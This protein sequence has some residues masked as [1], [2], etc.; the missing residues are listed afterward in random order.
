MTAT[1]IVDLRVVPIDRLDPHSRNVRRDLGDLGELADSIREQGLLEPLVVAGDGEAKRFTVV[2][3]HRRLAAAKLAGLTELPVLVR[4]D[5]VRDVDV[6]L[7]M[8]VENLQRADLTPVEE[9][10]AYEQ[11][12]LAGLSPA[13]IAKRTGRSRSTVDARLRLMDL[14]EQVRDQVHGRQVT[15]HEAA[16]LLEFTDRPDDL[17]ALE[18]AA[19]TRDFE[20]ELNRARAR[21]EKQ[22]EMARVRSELEARKVRIVTQSEVP[23]YWT[24]QL[25]WLHLDEAEHERSCPDHAAFITPGGYVQYLCLKP[26]QHPGREAQAPTQDDPEY[27]ER[28]AAAEA[29]REA[30]AA[31]AQT[32]RGFLLPLTTST[33]PAP[34]GLRDTVLRYLAGLLA[35][36]EYLDA[37][38]GGAW[39]FLTGKDTA[40]RKALGDPADAVR[41]L[42]A[43]RDPLRVVLAHLASSAE[44]ALT[45]TWAW[46]DLRALAEHLPWLEL[47]EQLGYE[48]STW[49]GERIAQARAGE[50]DADVGEPASCRVCGC[51][52]EEACAGGC[53]WAEPDL[54]SACAPV[55]IETVQVAGGVL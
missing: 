8:L 36:A 4:T 20:W 18:K 1:A 19:G 47:L 45:S 44:S 24:R 48:A 33:Q 42:T 39:E 55:P 51:T 52:D 27:A 34:A 6:T 22:R 17:K 40:A 13:L 31:S 10:V 41:A 53:S 46:T 23:Q 50:Q 15:L 25:E 29:L 35:G 11:L 26:E 37:D 2:A 12:Q 43:R 49:E 9:A 38:A 5:L 7:A 28:T 32:R 30:I 14:P 21:A 16:A 54:C 3:G